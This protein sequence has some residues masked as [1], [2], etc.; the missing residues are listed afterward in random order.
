MHLLDLQ[1]QIGK[2]R[3]NKFENGIVILIMQIKSR[4]NLLVV[5]FGAGDLLM[6]LHDHK[7]E[8]IYRTNTK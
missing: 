3:R 1:K 4:T 8:Y 5:F 2:M 7:H 6:S